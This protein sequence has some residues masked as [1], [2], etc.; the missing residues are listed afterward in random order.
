MLLFWPIILSGKLVLAIV[1]LPITV[2]CICISKLISIF[3]I[4]TVSNKSLLEN[5]LDD[6]SPLKKDN[7]IK[8]KLNFKEH[9]P[10]KI[11]DNSSDGSFVP[12][13]EQKRS[14]E[15]D[16]SLKKGLTNLLLKKNLKKD[17]RSNYKNDR[18]RR[19]Q[20]LSSVELSSDCVSDKYS[21]KFVSI[22]GCSKRKSAIR[23]YQSSI[24]ILKNSPFKGSQTNLDKKRLTESKNC[25]N[26]IKDIKLSKK[27]SIDLSEATSAEFYEKNKLRHV[28]SR[29]LNYN[30]IYSSDK[31]NVR[32]PKNSCALLLVNSM[33]KRYEKSKVHTVSCPPLETRVIS[34]NES[35]SVFDAEDKKGKLEDREISLRVLDKGKYFSQNSDSRSPIE[36]RKGIRKSQEPSSNPAEC[37]SSGKN[38]QT[39][40][41]D[42]LNTKI[43]E[44]EGQK[45]VFCEFDSGESK[46]ESLVTAA[47]VLP[48]LKNAFEID[49]NAK[50]MKDDEVSAEKGTN[51]LTESSNDIKE[52][53]EKKIFETENRG[54]KLSEPKLRSLESSRSVAEF[55][56]PVDAKSKWLEMKKKYYGNDYKR[57][58]SLKVSESDKPESRNLNRINS[59]SKLPAQKIFQ[60]N[61]LVGRARQIGAESPLDN[62]HCNSSL[63]QFQLTHRQNRGIEESHGTQI[64]DEGDKKNH[65]QSVAKNF[66]RRLSQTQ[67]LSQWLSDSNGSSRT[68]KCLG[69]QKPKP[70]PRS[71][72]GGSFNQG[73]K[74]TGGTDHSFKIPKPVATTRFFNSS[75]SSLDVRAPDRKRLVDHVTNRINGPKIERFIGQRCV[76]E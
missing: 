18:S 57:V 67:S 12:L 4:K 69:E 43:T 30:N 17:D 73:F 35:F 29:I 6:S 58:E 65:S 26:K 56:K 7:K 44:S 50:R 13:E 16:K 41:P 22:R 36:T 38:D 24:S 45:I 10:N 54:S 14:I 74:T 5:E 9:L 52:V 19:Q 25:F 75:V 60:Y 62:D 32:S 59:I 66:H 23:Q 28:D 27:V 21:G 47:D 46:T 63:R 37:D 20:D 39:K 64:C 15:D 61:M 42:V 33:K 31:Y 11:E 40:I 72:Q 3:G 34:E 55:T 68:K 71:D 76:S 70:K 2:L 51:F 53:S 8:E 48:R 1:S 49:V